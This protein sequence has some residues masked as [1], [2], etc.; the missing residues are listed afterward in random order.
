VRLNEYDWG[1]PGA[2]AVVC[3]HGVCA[4]GRRFRRLA[5]E[6]LADSFHVRA[7]DLRGHGGSGWD[8]P[9]TI[10]AHAADLLETVT[11]PATWIGHSFGGRLVAEVTAM[12]VGTRV[13]LWG[14]IDPETTH[15]VLQA[16]AKSRPW[17]W[18]PS[19][20]E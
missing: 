15:A 6:H 5:E 17:T 7:L 13:E 4:H 14:H 20:D 3:L 12:D 16:L 10:E 19:W 2:P 8:E 11:E 18:A 9:W 1:S